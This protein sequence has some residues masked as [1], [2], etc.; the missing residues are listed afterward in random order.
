MRKMNA[1]LSL[2]STQNFVQIFLTT[3]EIIG[4]IDIYGSGS[5][6]LPEHS[7]IIHRSP[8]VNR[9]LLVITL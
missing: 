3:P 6:D 2:T 9:E 4:C 7:T 1:E 8:V 5:F